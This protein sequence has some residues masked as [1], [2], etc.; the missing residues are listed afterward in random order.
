MRRSALLFLLELFWRFL[1]LHLHKVICL[2]LFA[3][4]ITQISLMY[5]ALLIFLLTLVVPIPF[6]NP[7]TYPLMTFYLGLV[8]IVKMVYQ[9]PV[10]MESHFEFSSGRNRCM[11]VEVS[12]GMCRGG[13][14]GRG[15]GREE[16]RKGGRRGQDGG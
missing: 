2:V 6:I 11:D 13:E 9:V 8:T 4:T 15:R 5:W 7:L 1:E 16:E 12:G 3:T 10:V 14:G